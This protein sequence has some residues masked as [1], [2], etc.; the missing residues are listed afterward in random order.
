MERGRTSEKTPPMA[1]MPYRMHEAQLSIPAS[2]RDQTMQMFRIP[3]VPGEASFVVT[4]DCQPSTRDAKP[5]AD[6]QLAALEHQFPE[7]RALASTEK[8][9]GTQRIAVLDY[10]WRTDKLML[11]QRQAYVPAPAC[12]LT[13]TLTARPETFDQ[14]EWAW[15][16]VL[17]SLRLYAPQPAPGPLP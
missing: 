2:W 15:T 17:S 5:Y 6:A 4:R 7:F 14:L 3:D 9:L 10:Q 11:R 13:L 12:M 1:V 16:L 8:Q